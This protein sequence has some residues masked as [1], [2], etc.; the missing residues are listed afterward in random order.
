MKM[1]ANHYSTLRRKIHTELDRNGTSATAVAK[2]H[3]ENENFAHTKDKKTDPSRS[4]ILAVMWNTVSSQWVCDELY[5]YL[6]DRHIETALRN[7]LAPEILILNNL[8]EK[9]VK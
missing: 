5:P 3:A 1:L 6:D 2:R 7:I 9:V 8:L 4:F